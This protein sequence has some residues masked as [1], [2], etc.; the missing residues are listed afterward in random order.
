M[1]LFTSIGIALG[2]TA[3]AS[4]AGI[5]AFGV[6]VAATGLAASAIG[7]SVYSATQANRK[8]SMPAMPQALAIGAAETFAKS[9]AR[10]KSI[11]ASRSQSVFTSPLG[12]GGEADLTRKTLLGQ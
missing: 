6:G 4:A 7:S 8:P 12:I 11:S 2:A 1:P 10:Q 9:A 3:A 5:G